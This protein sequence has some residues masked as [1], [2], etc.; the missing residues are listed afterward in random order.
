MDGQHPIELA[1]L[2]Q[3]GRLRTAP[4]S[5][6]WLPF[7]A[8]H[9]ASAQVPRFTWDARVR[10][11]PFVHIRVQDGYDAGRG[12]G[13]VSLLSA[14]RIAERSGTP[15]LS[16]GALHR[17]LAEA[18]WYPTALLPRSNLVWTP[19][20]DSRAVAT[21]TDHATTV[22]LE[23][24][25]DEAGEVAAVLAEGRWGT[26]GGRFMKLPWAGRFGEYRR[27]DGM[28]V[29]TRGEAAWCWS[30]EWTTVWEGR[31]TSAAYELAP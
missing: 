22:S 2:W 20:D 9:V 27:M 19:V 8:T 10:V 28:L 16:S 23:F 18:V 11:L 31:I 26:F 3:N 1:R 17:Y 14:I 12:S 4:D 13:R 25:F 21:L 6:R 29:P 30:G 7:R 24:R 15:E 5:R